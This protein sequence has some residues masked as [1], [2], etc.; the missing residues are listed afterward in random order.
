VPAAGVHHWDAEADVVIVGYGV[1]GAAAAIGAAAGGADVLLLERTGGWGGA[2]SLAGGLI[3]LGGGT[4]LQKACGFDDTPDE[5][6][7]FLTAALGPGADAAKLAI[8]AERGV[9]HFGWLMDCGVPFRNV[10]FDKPA[11]EPYGAAGYGRSA[12]RTASTT[13]A[14]GW[15]GSHSAACAPTSTARS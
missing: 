8:Y 10:F 12:R 1:A 3:Y 4:V 14:A 11:W 2:A 15:P 7:A 5:M 13:C 6:H 9:E